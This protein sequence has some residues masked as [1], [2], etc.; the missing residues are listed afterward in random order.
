MNLAVVILLVQIYVCSSDVF[1]L[2]VTDVDECEEQDSCHA[3]ALCTNTKGGFNCSCLDGYR[4]DGFSCFGMCIALVTCV[5]S[6]L[7]Q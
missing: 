3:N 7:F 4:G 5:V 1:L 2:H 6:N